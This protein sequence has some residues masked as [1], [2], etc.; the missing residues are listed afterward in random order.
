MMTY[1]ADDCRLED[2]IY[3]APFMGKQAI[4][5]Y[6][7]KLL[8]GLPDDLQFVIDDVSDAGSGGAVGMIW[9][10]EVDGVVVPFS[11]GASFYRCNADNLL[12]FAR[13]VPEPSFKLGDRV[14]GVLQGVVWVMK[15]VP[16]AKAV[17]SQMKF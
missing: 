6:L 16:G 9:H 2:M 10:A 3:S 5:Q 15:N 11:R 13:D 7:G 4:Q 17:A 8:G 14:M 12:I 1:L